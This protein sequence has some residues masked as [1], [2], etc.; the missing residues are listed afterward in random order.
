MATVLRSTDAKVLPVLFTAAEAAGTC[1]DNAAA[2]SLQSGMPC[3]LLALAMHRVL[4]RKYHAGADGSVCDLLAWNRM[5]VA[6]E[7]LPM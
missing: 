6:V 1:G 4:E 2:D 3:E 7:N 5:N